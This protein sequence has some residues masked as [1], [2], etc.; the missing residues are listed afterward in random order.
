[1]QTF[2]KVSR[3]L[4]LLLIGV[5]A[6][7]LMAQ[8]Y[9]GGVSGI[10]TDSA[11][12]VVANAKLTL[13]DNGTGATLTSE[14]TSAG[15]YAF[16]D[17]Q[18][19]TYTLTVDAQGFAQN[20]IEQIVVRPGQVYSLAVKLS[21]ASATQQVEVNAAAISLD[22]QSSTNNA[23]VNET[24]VANIPLNGRDF[25]QLVKIVPG[26]NGAGSING[27]RT[28]QNNYQIDGADNNDIFQNAPAANQAGVNG[29]AGVTLPIDAI[30]QFNV[31]SN[32]N[33][34]AG[35]NVGSLVSLAIKTGTNKFHGA[36]YYFNRNEFF[37]AQNPFILSP[38]KVELRNI[39]FGADVGGPIIKD[40]LFFFV[41][42]ERQRFVIGGTAPATEPTSQ[43]VTA[44]TNLLKAHNIPI[45]PLSL[46][47]L[48]LWPDGNR[49]PSN[50]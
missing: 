6:P 5:A 13:V 23:V 22:T 46:S 30:D 38:K 39:Q 35:R 27:A 50:T 29:I 26:Y 43:Y 3:I 8:T 17:L 11:G 32:G 12:A 7:T 47:V 36:G 25:T 44:G 37:A 48:S 24:A 15:D 45:N 49:C 9:R 28:N 20:K 21:I 18:L 34:E 16:Q 31:Q 40:K 19:G 41:N 33:A 10:V 42:Y 2:S 4:L 14:S 1:M